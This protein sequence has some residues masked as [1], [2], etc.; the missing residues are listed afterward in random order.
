M[1]TQ[2]SC[3]KCGTPFMAEIH[4]L[5][6]SQRQPELKQMLLSGQLNVAVCPSCQAM[7][8]LA[9]PLVFHDA[10]HEM[11][12]IHVPQEM[13]LNTM[14]REEMVG[15]LTRGLIDSLPPEQRRGYL[16]QPQTILT[17]QTFMEKVLE[18]E[19]VTKEMIERQR[20]Q[21]ELL[22][23]MAKAD[24]DVV[25]FLLKQREREIDETFFAMLRQYIQTA[26]QMNDDK[27]LI[28][29]VNL[30]ALLM[31]KTAVGRR[32]EKQQVAMHRFN[33]AAKK[34]GGL[35]AELLL[36]HVLHNME[37]ESVVQGLVMAGQR[38][39]SYEFFTLLTTEIEK[40]EGA[41]NIAKA[42][43]LQRL[44][45]DLLK[46]FEEMRQ[47]SQRV[48][49]EADQVLQQILQSP[50]LEGAIQQYGDQIDDAF[51][52]V[53]S[54]RIAEA[55]QG[56][57]NE[58]YQRLNQIQAFLMRQVENQA[59]PEIQLLTQLVQTESEAE[60]QQI[61]DENADLLSADL[62]QVVN[63]LLDQIKANPGRNDGMQGRL[64]GVRAL[65][66]ARVAG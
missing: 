1:Q 51:M 63:M 38:A 18:T 10:P 55:E 40:E 29:L 17:L 58:L 35:S 60:Q 43:Q 52:Y 54:R 64:E 16:L 26:Q 39:L 32:I 4:Q 59:P 24:T 23:T 48:V 9:S 46:L 66:Q 31:T 22:N 50:T 15:R 37:D 2:I 62:V 28:K 61:L 56:D 20:K 6:D 45:G 5:I 49:N 25:E 3:P 14:Q 57:D 47:E 27:S 36:E 7:T 21:A 41:G 53:L 8:Q 34:Q 19:G 30:Q 33:Q 44:R 13:H 11:F 12:L 42:A 65:I